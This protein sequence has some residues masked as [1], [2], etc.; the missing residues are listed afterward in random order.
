MLTRVHPELPWTRI[1]M[2]P[3]GTDGQRF[4][5]VIPC[6]PC[7]ARPEYRFEAAVAGDTPAGASMTVRWPAE[8][9]EPSRYDVGYERE[10]HAGGGAVL[11]AAPASHATVGRAFTP[12]AE[13]W[14]SPV[15]SIAGSVD[16]VVTARW[17]AFDGDG[18]DGPARC[19]LAVRG[20]PVA[21]WT[22]IRVDPRPPVDA[23]TPWVDISEAVRR[24]LPAAD[25]V[26][27]AIWSEGG[28]AVGGGGGRLLRPRLV[29]IRC[30]PP[31]GPDVDGDGLVGLADLLLVFEA[32][33]P[34]D[35]PRECPADVSGDGR[36][37]LADVLLVVAAWGTDGAA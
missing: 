18:S 35:S 31:A 5:A 9:D 27:V 26:Q 12:P 11:R 33:G 10:R 20:G 25:A 24:H 15:W 17:I 30:T 28:G 4:Q 6:A 23:G 22:V 1:P 34:C 36:V 7:H 19:V 21:A 32:F 3:L 29:E 37:D 16:P 13:A 14:R 8:A 2:R